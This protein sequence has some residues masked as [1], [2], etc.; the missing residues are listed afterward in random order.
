VG[1]DLLGLIGVLVRVLEDV[2]DRH[3]CSLLAVA[4]LVAG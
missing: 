4:P 2:A 1:P 3:D